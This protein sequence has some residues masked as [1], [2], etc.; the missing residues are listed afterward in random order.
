[1]TVPGRSGPLMLCGVSRAARWSLGENAL[2]LLL[3]SCS[4]CS[5]QSQELTAVP[6]LHDS[7]IS[8]QEGHR[9]SPS[10]ELTMTGQ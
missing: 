2:A 4:D 3:G 9:G 5:F 7:N 6:G 10:T 1:M 8:G